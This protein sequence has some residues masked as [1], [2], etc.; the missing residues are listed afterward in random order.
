MKTEGIISLKVTKI[1]KMG[2][3]VPLDWTY[4]VHFSDKVRRSYLLRRQVRLLSGQKGLPINSVLS[5]IVDGIIDVKKDVYN[6][7]RVTTPG[8]GFGSLVP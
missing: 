2:I 7:T 6:E 3:I 1:G 5:V 4:K 8:Q